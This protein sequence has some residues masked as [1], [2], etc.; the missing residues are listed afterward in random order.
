MP[1]YV[2]SEVAISSDPGLAG[3]PFYNKGRLVK[4]IVWLDVPLHAIREITHWIPVLRPVKDSWQKGYCSIYVRSLTPLFTT[5]WIIGS[6][7]K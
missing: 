4:K 7:T 6:S 1:A 2:W 3:L 5:L